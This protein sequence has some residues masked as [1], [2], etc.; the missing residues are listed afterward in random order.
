MKSFIFIFSLSF[1]YPLLSQSESADVTILTQNPAIYFR[2]F[3]STEGKSFANFD[4]RG[5]CNDQGNADLTF[6]YK[7]ESKKEE[8]DQ[9]KSHAFEKDFYKSCAENP[10]DYIYSNYD[11]KCKKG[12]FHLQFL[13]CFR[14]IDLD[15]KNTK[16]YR[17]TISL[18]ESKKETIIVCQN[19]LDWCD[20]E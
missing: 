20:S 11:H 12:R 7:V 5:R 3:N 19:K 17:F 4:I 9:W 6:H 1:F 15:T 2:N 16:K 13:R 8:K 18:G 10:I 14:K